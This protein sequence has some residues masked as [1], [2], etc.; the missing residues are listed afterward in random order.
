MEQRDS[1]LELLLHGRV[2]GGGKL[3]R[4]HLAEIAE[5]LSRPVTRIETEEDLDT[6]WLQRFTKVGV[7]AGASTPNSKV[8]EVIER[9]AACYGVS[10]QAGTRTC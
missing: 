9:L 10:L 1:A 4:P 6:T 3:D 5:S 8:G 7:M 2:A